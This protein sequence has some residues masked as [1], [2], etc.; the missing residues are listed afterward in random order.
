MYMKKNES[1]SAWMCN[2]DCQYHCID[3]FD[4]FR[5]IQICNGTNA[6]RG[7]DR[8]TVSR[9]TAYGSTG[10]DGNIDSSID[11]EKTPVKVKF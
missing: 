9:N 6:K 5:T 11:F 8:R 1:L 7:N 4:T 2:A 3:S 10:F